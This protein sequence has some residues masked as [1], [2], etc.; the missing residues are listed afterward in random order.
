MKLAQDT[1]TVT[2]HGLQ[3]TGQFKIRQNAKMFAV[4]TS[5]IYSDKP[6][7]IIRE[8][9]CNAWDAHKEAGQTDQFVVM[10]PSHTSP[11]LVIRDFGNGLSHDNIMN[12]YTTFFDSTKDQSNDAVGAFGLGSKSPF[13]YT[14]AFTVTSR[15]NGTKRVYAAVKDDAGMPSISLIVE[16]EDF[17]PDG[18]EVSVPVSPNDFERFNAAAAATLKHFPSDSYKVYGV[19]VPPMAY[20]VQTDKWALYDNRHNSSKAVMGP[21]AYDVDFA[22]ADLPM[23][24]RNGMEFRF[25]LG[26]VSISPSRESLSIDKRTIAALKARFDDFLV[27]IRKNVEDSVALAPT[28]WE[29]TSNFAKAQAAANGPAKSV[30]PDSCA[31][32]NQKVGTGITILRSTTQAHGE[33]KSVYTSHLHYS[34]NR[35]ASMELSIAIRPDTTTVVVD[36]LYDDKSP[37]LWAR[38]SSNQS[39]FTGTTRIVLVQGKDAA[40]TANILKEMGDPTTTIPL[41]SLVPPATIPTTHNYNGVSRGIPA[42]YKYDKADSWSKRRTDWL[43]VEENL[44][45]KHTSG[46]Y[47]ALSGR[48]VDT[49]A[50]PNAEKYLACP[51]LKNKK[52][53]YGFPKKA[54]KV[55]DMAEFTPI[56][57][58]VQGEWKRITSSDAIW[59]QFVARKILARYSCSFLDGDANYI[60]SSKAPAHAAYLD[61]VKELRNKARLVSSTDYLTFEYF[62]D[63]PKLFPTDR[64]LGAVVSKLTAL[65]IAA[66]N[67]L[68]L[69]HELLDATNAS[70][71]TI[72]KSGLLLKL[73]NMEAASQ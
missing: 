12:L 10:M 37:R 14:D 32:N 23:E 4:L 2:S 69:L 24:M 59:D 18:L 43:L 42:F 3:E 48:D 30:F 21:V 71:S 16:M 41:S 19:T 39:K 34:N 31:W 54:R 68:P 61:Y 27:N 73:I 63:N 53:L 36:D 51:M 50:M 15:Q 72:S 13:A 46:V 1:R 55:F 44:A 64:S 60:K 40:A 57:D 7:A 35:M 33:I 8:L 62:L 26:E 28:L 29:A 6:R 47:V 66:I 25:E 49:E 20:T 22:A 56:E 58:Y 45:S 11:M 17:E 9:V 38:L 52:D 65:R 70:L 5:N 67:E